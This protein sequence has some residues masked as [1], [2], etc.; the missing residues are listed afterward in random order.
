MSRHA[1]HMLAIGWSTTSSHQPSYPAPR[2]CQ[3]GSFTGAVSGVEKQGEAATK[4][5][6][7]VLAVQLRRG[8]R[9]GGRLH[10]H[11]ARGRRKREQGGQDGQRNQQ[12]QRGGERGVQAALSGAASGS[13]KGREAAQQCLRRPVG[14]PKHG[15][16]PSVR[17]GLRKGG[18]GERERL[19]SR[20][21]RGCISGASAVH[22]RRQRGRQ[23]CMH[24]PP[25]ART[26]QKEKVDKRGGSQLAHSSSLSPAW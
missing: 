19:E 3:A 2:I 12:N 22:M 10:E 20:G 18:R 14:C 1:R 13:G 21:G 8:R 9:S 16:S 11:K 7:A 25:A 23:L 4:A 5:G 15:C 17:K 24:V 6:R 26:A